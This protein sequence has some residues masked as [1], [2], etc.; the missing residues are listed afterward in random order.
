MQP[1]I[2]EHGVM[3]N[4]ITALTRFPLPDHLRAEQIRTA[5]TE[6]APHFR[7]VPGLVRKLFLLSPDGRIGGGVYL[8]EDEVA[9][10]SFMLDRVATMIRARFR[11]EP[12][13]EFFES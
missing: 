2:R 3:K 5:F 4:M 1:R 11:V 8:W 6:A 13:I 7:N 12:T 10:R 9:A